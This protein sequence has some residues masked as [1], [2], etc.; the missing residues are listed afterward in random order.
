MR[1]VQDS[2]EEISSQFSRLMRELL[3]GRIS[4]NTFQPWEIELLLDIEN[5]H[6][7]E[8]AR[9]NILKRYQK[10]VG[11]DL[12]KGA[13]MPMKLSEYLVRKR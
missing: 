4:R 2:G 9:E 1:N 11:R 13:A 12:E 7:R 8:S 6:L 5:C 10:A 3:R